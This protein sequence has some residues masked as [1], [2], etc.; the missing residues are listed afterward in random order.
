MVTNMWQNSVNHRINGLTVR[1]N[2]SRQIVSQRN[3]NQNLWID[4]KKIAN[5]DQ[6]DHPDQSPGSIPL[7]G[8]IP[9]RIS[10][11]PFRIKKNVV[12]L[13]CLGKK[14]RSIPFQTALV[15][16]PPRWLR[17]K[18]NPDHQDRW[19]FGSRSSCRWPRYDHPSWSR[20]N[21]VKIYPSSDVP[22]FDNRKNRFFSNF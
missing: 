20:K 21:L 18:I 11:I 19:L 3:R 5:R 12:P 16:P 17:K 6:S 7:T 15:T 14:P 2:L 8:T 1:G 10:Q 13:R 9:S 4:A 22:K